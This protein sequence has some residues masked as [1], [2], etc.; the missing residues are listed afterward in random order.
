MVL[1]TNFRYIF[2]L[3]YGVKSLQQK[4]C[5]VLN[6]CQINIYHPPPSSRL[7]LEGDSCLASL[8]DLVSQLYRALQE[9]V[10]SRTWTWPLV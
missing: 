4:S 2:S 5:F 1:L 10:V 7:H 6:V 8:Q 3:Y 9:G